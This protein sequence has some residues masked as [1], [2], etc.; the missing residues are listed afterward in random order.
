MVKSAA[1]ASFSTPQRGRFF[2]HD[3]LF[4]QFIINFS[5]YSPIFLQQSNFH[6]NTRHFA[7]SPKNVLSAGRGGVSFAGK[8]FPCASFPVSMSKLAAL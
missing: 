5:L 4:F 7:L 8:C 1:F 6:L 2:K 3:L